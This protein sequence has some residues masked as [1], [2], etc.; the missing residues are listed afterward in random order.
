[1]KAALPLN[2][3]TDRSRRDGSMEKR[4]YFGSGLGKIKPDNGAAIRGIRSKDCSLMT[5]DCVGDEASRVTQQSGPQ[6]SAAP[7]A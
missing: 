4:S 2:L 3:A 7:E 5:I 1:M 6:A